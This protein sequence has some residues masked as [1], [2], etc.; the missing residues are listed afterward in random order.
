MGVLID[1][2]QKHKHRVF[3]EEKLDDIGAGFEHTPGK[4]LKRLAHVTGA[5][6]PSAR[7]TTQLLKLRPCKTTEIY[8]CLA[9]MRST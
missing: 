7:R 5:S 2:K 3:T 4:S 8:A 6:N 1:K 9:V